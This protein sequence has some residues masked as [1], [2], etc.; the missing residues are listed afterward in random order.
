MAKESGISRT[1]ISTLEII[2]TTLNQGSA[3][4]SGRTKISTSGSTSK[5]YGMGTG[6]CIIT[7]ATTTKATG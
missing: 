2:R 7:T 3:F 4:I 5:T 6:S 1:E